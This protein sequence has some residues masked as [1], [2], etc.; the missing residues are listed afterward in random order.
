MKDLFGKDIEKR[1]KKVD[2][3][4]GRKN[5]HPYPPGTG[6]EGETCGTCA[7][8]CK[9]EYHDKIYYKCAYMKH[10]WTH[11]LGTDLRLKDEACFLWKEQQCAKKK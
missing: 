8:C 9:I 2:R 7:K 5:A 4:K 3:Y 10:A 6:P 11:G 1:Q